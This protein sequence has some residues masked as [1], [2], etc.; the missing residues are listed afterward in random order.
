MS[1]LRRVMRPDIRFQ[2]VAGQ[3]TYESQ[4]NAHRLLPETTQ[5]AGGGD[6]ARRQGDCLYCH[7]AHGGP[8][9]Y[10]GLRDTFRPPSASTLTTDQTGGAYAAI[11]FDCHG[12]ATPSGFSTAPVDIK[13]FATGSGAGAGHRIQTSGGDLPVGSPLPCY[14][15]HGPHGSTRDNKSLLSDALGSG[16]NTDDSAAVR[17]FCFSCHTTADTASG[18]E[19]ELST[20]SA[21]VASDT[22]A[23]LSRG[24]TATLLRLPPVSGHRVDDVA[25]CYSCHGGDYEPGGL[26][27]HNPSTGQVPGH[28]SPT[29]NVLRY[30]LP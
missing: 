21:E 30:R 29:S 11:C 10:D 13:Q 6:V 7:S 8:N 9:N 15:C 5:T 12:G 14:E 24:S 23:G 1:R 26:N 25:S 3:N 28:T 20:Y 18:W 2:D 22:V 4:W 27:V 16:L 17:K 19:S